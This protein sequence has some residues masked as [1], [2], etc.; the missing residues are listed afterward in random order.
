MHKS[1][2]NVLAKLRSYPV[3]S[4]KTAQA[5]ARRL[6]VPLKPHVTRRRLLLIGGVLCSLFATVYTAQFFWPRT[7]SFSYSRPTC[8][9]NPILLPGWLDV[10]PGGTFRASLS[11]SYHSL[12]SHT[13]C[14]TPA[15]PPQANSS[16][17][18]SFGVLGPFK[19]TVH[20]VTGPR[21]LLK[22]EG[23][24]DRPIPTRQP[25]AFKLDQLDQIFEY[26]L[27]ANDKKIP[28]PIQERTVICDI[29]KLE[30]AQSATYKLNLQRV[31]RDTPTETI[32]DQA[33]TTVEA[34]QI[35][36]SSV[37]GG[38]TVYDKPSE[39]TLTLNK[40]AVSLSGVRLQEV[41]GETRKDL[42]ASASVQD[43]TVTVR[44]D[45]PLPRN[46]AIALTIDQINAPDGGYLVAPFSL[47]FKTSGGPKVLGV[48]IGSSRVSASGAVVITLDTPIGAGQA[49]G[50]FIRL[51]ANGAAV[52]ATVSAQ[53]KT[54]TLKPQGALP[55]CAALTVKVLD[56]LQNIHGIAGGSAWQFKSR[57]LCQSVFSIGT[58]VLGRSITAYSFGSGPSKI[59]FVGTT[60]GDETSSTTLL[61]KWVDYLESNGARIPAH[62]TIIVIPSLNPDGYAAGTRT[63]AHNVD[64]N[65]NFPSNNWKAGVTMPNKSFLPQGGGSAPLSEPESRALANYV[66]GQNP[67]LVLT[68][69]AAGG[70]VVPNDSGDSYSLAVT[71]GKQSSVGFMPNGQTATFFEY[72]TTGAFEDW[73]HDKPALP[74]LLIELLN[75]TG[76]EFGGHTNALWSIA[77]LP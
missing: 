45:Q 70:V 38:S 51:E 76:N 48:N 16:E 32:L 13:S 64:L 10:H 73:L 30:L 35:T 8:F 63:N 71:Y 24:L 61:N 7:V 19:K 54:I 34:I 62:R 27:A 26:E 75:K 23:K 4:Y 9:T 37:A 42:P 67:R 50:E 6:W 58:S 1:I 18:L 25:L 12:Y 52:A 33:I 43:K 39:M 28:C 21:P 69:H 22:A 20:I 77:N 55:R 57:V 65:R 53:G 3:L 14:V 59:I 56:G 46:V 15:R 74:A 2:R 72:D 68:Y 66:L 47:G 41:A 17:T 44:F 29:A 31:F 60:H 40:P 49:L 36:G 11:K 5:A